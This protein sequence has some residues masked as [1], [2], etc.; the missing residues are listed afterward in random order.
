MVKFMYKGIAFFDLDH[1]LLN[2]QTKVDPEVAEAMKQLR[3]NNVLP[4]ISTGRNIFEIPEILEKIEIDTVVSANGDYVLFE[5]KPV[6]E[7]IIKPEI[8]TKFMDFAKS[9]NESTTVMNNL[10]AAI[11]FVTDDTKNNY[12]SINT[13]IPPLGAEDFVKQHPIYMMV[14]NTVGHDQKYIDTFDDTLTFYRNTPFSMD[15]V[16]KNGSKKRGIQELISN[17]G[18]NGIPTYGF[19]DGNN[20][21]PMLQYVDHPVVMGNGLPHVKEYAEFITTNNTDHGIVNGLKHYDLI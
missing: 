7:A 11:N 20:D 19:G 18:L 3:R 9:M 16:V 12:Q 17:A 8:V 5:N 6:Y 1:T 13:R 4:V 2:E 14:V 15:V 10:G 21:V